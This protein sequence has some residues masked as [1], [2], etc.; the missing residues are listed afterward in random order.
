MACLAAPK[1]PT[2]FPIGI[3]LGVPKLG[4]GINLGINLCCQFNIPL[5]VSTDDLIALLQAAGINI[6]TLSL[7]ADLLKPIQ[8]YLLAANKFIDKLELNCPL[9]G[10]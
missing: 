10:T 7:N 6:H 5:S 4:I 3:T 2:T 9:D 1:L 8:A